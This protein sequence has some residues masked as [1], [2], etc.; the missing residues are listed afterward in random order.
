MTQITVRW[1]RGEQTFSSDRPVRV[2]RSAECDVLVLDERVSRDPHLELRYEGGTWV[3]EDRSRGGTWYE[4]HKVDRVSVPTA[5]TFHLGAPDGPE[6]TLLPGVPADG[7]P[8]DE[9]PADETPADEVASVPAGAHPADGAGAPPAEPADDPLLAAAAAVQA[10]SMLT[11][12]PPGLEPAVPSPPSPPAPPAPPA[13]APPTGATAPPPAPPGPPPTAPPG[14]PPGA[15]PRFDPTATVSID[16]RALRLSYEDQD[17]LVPPGYMITIG[18]DPAECQLVVD[19]AIVS[20]HHCRFTHDGTHWIL[21]DLGSTRGTFVD[22]K[23]LT[24]PYRAEGVFE[25][26]L[27]DDD[28]GEKVRVVTVGEHTAPKNRLPLVLAGIGVVLA[29]AA[30]GAALLLGGDDGGTRV[31]QVT[32]SDSSAANT[33]E[34]LTAVKDA[35]VLIEAVDEDGFS[36]W[37]GSGTVITDEGHILT[38]AHVADPG[39]RSLDALVPLLGGLEDRTPAAGFVI[40]VSPS[41]DQP[42]EARYLA[43]WVAS[44]DTQDASIIKITESLDGSPV[45]PLPMEP[46]PIGSSTDLRAG[47]SVQSLGF[48]ANL[49]TTSVSVVE[50]EVVS[51]I[52]GQ[53]FEDIV[54]GDNRRLI[55]TSAVLGSGSSGGPVARG[56]KIV[57]INFTLSSGDN[58]DRGWAVPISEIQPLLAEVGLSS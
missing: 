49:T 29:L 17:H 39:A 22:G 1:S 56:G 31:E 3:L 14:P 33:P 41:E 50:G 23:R 42:V 36:L 20:R 5:T 58:L 4:G 19:S 26:S 57:G 46:V 47:Q 51:F 35:T 9:T 8:A 48:P 30:I 13:T 54:G 2:G 12:E 28:A 25:V 52:N 38:N 6:L 45:L 7:A 21:E 15:A 40:H 43:E 53:D 10:G 44:S 27:G 32:V 24:G 34:Q 55:N 37:T 16:D 11:P 18:R